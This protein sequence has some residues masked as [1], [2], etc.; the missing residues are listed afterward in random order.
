MSW[1]VIQFPMSQHA[2]TQSKQSGD[3]NTSACDL[4][5][6]Y[7]QWIHRI[8]FPRNY[9]KIAEQLFLNELWTVL[10]HKQI[11]QEYLR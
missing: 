8:T 1:N 3:R 10:S 9:P 7:K 4:H 6:Y 2:E 5:L 11:N